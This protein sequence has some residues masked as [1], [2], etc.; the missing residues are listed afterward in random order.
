MSRRPR[1]LGDV[2]PTLKERLAP[3]TALAD[4]QEA[5][6]SAAGAEV[7]RHCEPS[8]ER[9]GVLTVRCDSG[10]WAAELS[11]MTSQLIERLNEARDPGR[12]VREIRFVVQA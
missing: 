7:A 12:P 8:S 2:L 11:M 5:W 10:V 4:V 1:P 9:G 3:R 6:E